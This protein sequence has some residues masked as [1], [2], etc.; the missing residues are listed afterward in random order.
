MKKSAVRSA[1]RIVP[2]P[3]I[4]KTSHYKVTPRVISK[5]LSPILSYLCLSTLRD[6]PRWVSL[7]PCPQ[8]LSPWGR[9]E[10]VPQPAGC[11]TSL[12]PSACDCTRQHSHLTPLTPRP[13]PPPHSHLPSHPFPSQPTTTG[14]MLFTFS[15]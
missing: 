9:G 15:M 14:Q 13:H 1:L 5:A 4:R 3:F 6:S 8:P 11:T 2:N 12:L 7:L 10:G